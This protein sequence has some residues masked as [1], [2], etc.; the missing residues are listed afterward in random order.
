[1]KTKSQVFIYS[2]ASTV[3]MMCL[4]FMAVAFLSSCD[5]SNDDVVTNQSSPKKSEKDSSM[6]QPITY[7]KKDGLNFSR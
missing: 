5:K 4:S 3:K 1:M 7:V 6:D 2:K